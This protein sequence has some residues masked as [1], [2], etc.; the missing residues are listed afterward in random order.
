MNKNDFLKPK[1]VDI[2]AMSSTHAKISIEPLE[3]GFGHTLGNALR[4]VLLSSLP[5]SAVTEVTIENIL[6]EYSTIEGVQED[7]LEILL[8]IKKLALV[9]H[10]K[11]SANI[12]LRK[13]GIGPVLAS[14]ITESADLEI[15]NPAFCIANITNDKTEL[16][17]NMTVTRGRGYQQA[18]K[19]KF[20]EQEDLG[21]GKMQL[22]ASFSPV[23]QV[24]YNVDTARV[25]QRTD[26][27]KLVIEL[28]TNATIEPEDA[29]RKAGQILRN[30][31]DVFTYLEVQE[32]VE[33]DSDVPQI[34]PVL[35]RPVDD[36]ELTVRSANCLKAENIYYIG[37]LVQRSENELLKTPNLGKKSLTEIKDVL[38]THSLS[39]G[40]KLEDWPPKGIEK[41]L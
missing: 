28:K 5:G 24:T 31:L 39:L 20:N 21:I 29:I 6:H 17:I 13:K 23:V 9:L 36:L 2:E 4:R 35:L 18:Q 26:L 25:K 11:E 33:D 34:D 7:V 12:T 16:V 30:Q 15:K 41:R 38:A 27:D 40:I 19:R 22:D 14:D 32:D 3:R 37:D 1:L 10:E 8:N